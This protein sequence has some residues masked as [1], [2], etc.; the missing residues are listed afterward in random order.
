M[1][2]DDRYY[3]DQYWH[4]IPADALDD[5]QFVAMI[6][7]AEKYLDYPNVWNGSSISTS[8]DCSGL[9]SWVINQC[10]VG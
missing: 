6:Q 10:G 3:G 8:F 7:E 9:V 4:V 1:V 2:Y 5:E